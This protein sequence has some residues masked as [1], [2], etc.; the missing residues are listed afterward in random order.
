MKKKGTESSKTYT[1]SRK[2]HDVR[3]TLYHC[4]TSV[5]LAII[6]IRSMVQPSSVFKVTE[7]T[8]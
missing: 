7:I 2:D 8:H 5:H 3:S 4:S 1:L 6:I